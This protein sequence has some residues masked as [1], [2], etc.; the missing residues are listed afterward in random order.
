MCARFALE[1]AGE[2]P[3]SIRRALPAPLVLALSAAILERQS[4]VRPT[5][6]AVVIRGQ[7][8]APVVDACAW[9]L[10]PHWARDASI[11]RHTF[12]AR[13]ETLAEKPA[14]RDAF[15]HRRCLVPASHW[16][17]WTGPKG[18]R[19]PIAIQPAEGIGAFAGLWE[20][21]Q[22]ADGEPRRTFTVVT[23]PPVPAIADVHDRM[24][25]L[26]APQDWLRWLDGQPGES[27]PAPA[28]GPYG[29]QVLGP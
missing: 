8:A 25:L 2:L 13:V 14:F 5:D 26:L 7:S 16:V 18:H 9:G 11:A 3:E 1:F 28:A 23:C 19:T 17:E 24:P 15:R 10:I 21:W 4:S 22:P 12:N 6:R 27:I 29:R 20:S